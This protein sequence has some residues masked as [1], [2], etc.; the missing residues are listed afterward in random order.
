M[1]HTPR[2]WRR[3]L[4][5]LIALA[6]AGTSCEL[7]W[8]FQKAG[9]QRGTGQHSIYH[10]SENLELL[11]DEDSL[12]D[13]GDP[14]YAV[15]DGVQTAGP[16]S[17]NDMCEGAILLAVPSST[18]ASTAGST[19]DSPLA[20]TCNGIG[21]IG[22][23][24]WYTVVGTGG[25]I[26]AS[27]CNPATSLDTR[28]HVYTSAGG[29]AGPM[30]CAAGGSP[31]GNNNVMGCGVH[32]VVN[33]PSA[34]GVTY[35][36]LVS[37]NSAAGTGNFRLDIVTSGT[38]DN[39]GNAST[40][41][42]GSTPFSNFNAQTD[43]PAEPLCNFPTP[44]VP[45]NQL[46]RDIWYNYT[47]PSDGTLRIDMCQT[48]SID[49]RIAVYNG[50]SC[51]VVSPPID[52]DDDNEADPFTCGL[53]SRLDV[54]VFAGNC[55]KIR[56][57]GFNTAATGHG[58][59]TI[60]LSGIN[61]DPCPAAEIVASL[62]ASGLVDARQP[63]PPSGTPLQGIGSGSEPIQIQMPASITDAQ[64][65][66]ELCESTDGGLG[67]NAIATVQHAGGGL[68]NITLARPI[69]PGGVTTI[70]YLGGTGHVAYT[71][72]PAN[73]NADS[74]AAPT[75]ILFLID[76]LNG[77]QAP[78]HGLYSQD[79]DRSGVAGP[80]DILRLIDLL[81]GADAYPVWNGTPRPVNTKCP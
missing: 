12:V 54:P 4:C 1:Y 13:I 58:A 59:G 6:S 56:I 15:D 25:P 76:T 37:G 52:C 53:T 30:A 23:G 55:Y 68:Y 64:D 20:G 26:S 65:C 27:T 61:T 10:P 43:G 81:N 39:C 71:W 11:S 60:T 74:T 45:A 77:A 3:R 62:P 29:C 63:S 41:D 75:D 14:D 69:T 38:N 19:V 36:L 42:I 33:W 50:C 34:V 18:I 66:F 16:G 51:P 73:A 5:L 24:V 79:M 8:A 49:S 44:G 40:I 9:N 22:P 80:P 47:A 7:A 78:P 57:G 2:N 70:S 46:N 48:S 28:L 67:A 21:V 31:N 32:S 35:Y 72:H 17:G